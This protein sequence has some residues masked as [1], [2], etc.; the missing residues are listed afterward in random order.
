VGS[1]AWS[2]RGHLRTRKRSFEANIGERSRR[3]ASD[4]ASEGMIHLSPTGMRLNRSIPLLAVQSRLASR[5]ART[6]SAAKHRN[7]SSH[8]GSCAS[9][10]GQDHRQRLG[11]RAPPTGPPQQAG[12][13]ARGTP[14]KDR[15]SHW[16]RLRVLRHSPSSRRDETP[17]VT[18][19]ETA[20]AS[21]TVQSYPSIVPR[22]DTHRCRYGRGYVGGVY[23]L[24][25]RRGGA[26]D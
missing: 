13:E 15:Q 26:G 9:R 12:S 18:G 5:V 16:G 7:T 20:G 23:S 25:I 21:R 3:V 1:R 19:G 2:K 17:T 11:V 8:G 6:S 14:T 10:C 22:V 24:R 4:H